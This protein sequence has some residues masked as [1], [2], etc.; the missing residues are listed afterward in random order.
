MTNGG[1]AGD[2][3][4]SDAV[5]RLPGAQ[6]TT[7]RQAALARFLE[8]GFPTTREED[9][10]YTDLSLVAAISRRWLEAGAPKGDDS[11]AQELASQVVASIDA[12]WIVVANGSV[13]GLSAMTPPRG[14]AI[15]PLSETGSVSNPDAALADLNLALLRDGVHVHVAQGTALDVPLG[16]LFVDIAKD[17][18]DVS[19]TRARIEI[20]PGS[21]ASIIEYHVSNGAAEHYANS[22][23]EIALGD[24][25]VLNLVRVQDRAT[26]HSQTSHT[27]VR[28]GQRSVFRYG[29]F[30]LGGRL[31]RNDIG[32]DIVSEASEVEVA[33]L[34][35]A[36]QDQHIDNHVRIDHRTG[37]AKSHQEYRGILAGRCRGVWN[38]KTIV[39]EGADGTDAEQSNHNL[40]LSDRAEID[41]K[42]ELEIYADEVKCS[43]GTTVGQLDD[44]A[45]FYLR[46]RGLDEQEATRALTRAF[47]AGIIARLPIEEL[48]ESLTAK[49]EKRLA[50]LAGGELS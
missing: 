27:V 6:L 46:S 35:V 2:T 45:L 11:L 13:T 37:P 33:G 18:A 19:Q 25:A 28:N 21:S 15:S 12:H 16:L 50:D 10:K 8:R 36:G 17:S 41:A 29:G 1:F 39:H 7:A 32:I 22:V 49:V 26:N 42:P 14:V 20:E 31:I 23:M 38:G 30:D 48:A 34:Y 24:D 3:L 4:L 5:A 44:N 43:H 40:L 9:W 47:G